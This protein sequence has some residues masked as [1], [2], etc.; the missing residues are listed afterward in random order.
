MNYRH[1][2]HAGNFAD[3][4][5]HV[6]LVAL[7]KSFFHKETPFCYLD[8]HAGK[9]IYNLL[10]AE[11]TKSKEYE[12]GIAKVFEAHSAH[13][14]LKD[15]LTTITSINPKDKLQNYPGSPEI[16]SQLLRPQDRMVLSELQREE[17]ISL[18]NHF[19]R[20][21]KTKQIAVHEQDGY[22]SLKA[23]L[24]PK[25]KRGLILID[26]PYEDT[27]EFK[28]LL[29]L[30]PQALKRFETGVYAIWYPIKNRAPIDLFHRELKNKIARPMLVAELSVYNEDLPTHFN[31]S[32]L[33]IINPPWQLDTTLNAV[34][35][36]LWKTLSPE[37]AGRY[38]V[39][40]L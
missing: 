22:Q 32:G 4:F 39:K 1:T 9:G 6:T 12:N 30:I 28:K 14:L 5:K 3:V 29:D 10:S 23:F 16:V 11:A 24:P 31:G 27:N 15:Y 25:E 40:T 13:P 18:R 26:P 35:P 8:T 36:D 21:K 7:V 33:V 34:L 2:F 19:A 37:Q 20:S 17:Y 38:S